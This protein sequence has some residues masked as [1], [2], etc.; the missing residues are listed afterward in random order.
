MKEKEGRHVTEVPGGA[1][2]RC[3]STEYSVLPVLPQFIL[4]V[5][6][7]VPRDLQCVPRTL[8]EPPGPGCAQIPRSLATFG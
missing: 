4:R 5:S 7:F 6:P 8:H 1:A 2:L 3:D